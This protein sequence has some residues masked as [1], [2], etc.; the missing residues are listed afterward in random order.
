[1]SKKH[2]QLRLEALLLFGCLL[3]LIFLPD[4]P[5]HGDT[6]WGH[7]IIAHTPS[8]I[9]GSSHFAQVINYFIYKILSALKIISSVYDTM[10]FISIIFGAIYILIIYL[11]S[12]CF[13]RPTIRWSFFFTAFIS[14]V[15]VFFAGYREFGYYPIPLLIFSFYLMLQNKNKAETASFFAGIGSALHGLGFFFFP[16]LLFVLIYQKR[17]E[18]ITLLATSVTRI[19]A[20]Y[21]VFTGIPFIVYIIQPVTKF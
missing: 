16:G 11:I 6:S 10:N 7:F 15:T 20:F 17:K 19:T 13:T 3:V 14:P 18:K 5:C 4:M 21:F 12:Q 1:M 8:K 2:F 9:W